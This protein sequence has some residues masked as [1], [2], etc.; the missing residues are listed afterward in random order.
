M[1]LD[2]SRTYHQPPEGQEP[3]RYVWV[4]NPGCRASDNDRVRDALARPVEVSLD[5]R[6][7]VFR[8]QIEQLFRGKQLNSSAQCCL[9]CGDVRLRDGTYFADYP[10]ITNGCNIEINMMCREFKLTIVT[11]KGTITVDKFKPCEIPMWK[12]QV[13]VEI[14]HHIPVREQICTTEEWV[15]PQTQTLCRLQELG[16]I[17]GDTTIS[18]EQNNPN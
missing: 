18:V 8:E 3:L 2:L 6:I 9:L 13:C 10:T 17:G 14:L 7:D 12:L 15:I 1:F 5:V 16:W 4:W 11:P